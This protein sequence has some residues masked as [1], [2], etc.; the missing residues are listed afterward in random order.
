MSRR[1]IRGGLNNTSLGIDVGGDSAVVQAFLR[2]FD[3]ASVSS[4]NGS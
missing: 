2:L 4:Q 1:R 3:W